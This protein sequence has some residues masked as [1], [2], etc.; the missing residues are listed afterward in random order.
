M[1][2]R[3][4][5]MGCVLAVIMGMGMGTVSAADPYAPRHDPKCQIMDRYLK[6]FL[7]ADVRYL[8]RSDASQPGRMGLLELG[9]QANWAYFRL[10]IGDF[11]VSSGFLGTWFVDSGD[12]D[13]PNQLFMLRLPVTWIGRFDKGVSGRVTI[14]PGYY[15]DGERLAMDALYM[16]VSISLVRA[17][18]DDFSG[19]AGLE[20]RSGFERRWFPLFGA[21]W[22]PHAALRVEALLPRG[23]ISLAPGRDW[24]FRLGYAWDSIDY[25]LADDRKQVNMEDFRWTLGVTRVLHSEIEL[26]TEAGYV[27]DR[28]IIYRS[29]TADRV[30]VANTF[31]IRFGV[32]APF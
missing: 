2:R 21:V 32:A 14:K 13:L 29:D 28:R 18:A 7:D 23:G 16:P 31:F 20:Y 19:L 11:D 26:T 22:Q 5:L 1:K 17:F 12:I 4:R 24:R 30:N 6:P 8:Y 9:M 15:G 3:G 25:R 27:T 10:P